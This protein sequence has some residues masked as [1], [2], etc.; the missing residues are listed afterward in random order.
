LPSR[1]PYQGIVDE[2]RA[3]ILRG[4]LAGGERLPSENE[5]AERYRTSRPTVRRTIALL[6]AEGLVNTEQGGGAFR[7]AEAA[8]AVAAV[9]RELPSA[10]P[11]W[12]FGV[13]R[14][15]GGAGPDARAAI[16]RGGHDVQDRAVEVRDTVAA[17]DKHRFCYEVRMR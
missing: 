8:C 15:S 14:P 7:P 12:G 9:G 13:Q 16:A 10:P 3:S 2:L 4:R 1:F 11:R 5:L 17:A 6:K